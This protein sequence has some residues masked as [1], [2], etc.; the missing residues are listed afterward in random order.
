META[1]NDR[2]ACDIGYN[3]YKAWPS[4]EHPSSNM[5]LSQYLLKEWAANAT[6]EE[7][8]GIKFLVIHRDLAA[9]ANR[10]P[11]DLSLFHVTE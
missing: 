9:F 11:T 4:K 3:S 1:T 8:M 7:L 5:F 10:A 2:G 6:A